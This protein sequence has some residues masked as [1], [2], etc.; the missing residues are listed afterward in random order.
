MKKISIFTITLLTTLFFSG[1]GGDGTSAGTTAALIKSGETQNL[2]AGTTISTYSG[3]CTTSIVVQLD[4][5]WDVTNTST[6]SN[7]ICQYN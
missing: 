7:D 4:G 3:T 1:C 2:S 5:T 6:D